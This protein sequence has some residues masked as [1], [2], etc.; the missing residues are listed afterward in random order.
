MPE[1]HFVYQKFVNFTEW[2]VICIEHPGKLQTLLVQP[3]MFPG[4]EFSVGELYGFKDFLF[5]VKMFCEFLQQLR[6]SF[7]DNKNRSR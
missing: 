1:D 2:R 4:M 6:N 5:V 3:G 7:G